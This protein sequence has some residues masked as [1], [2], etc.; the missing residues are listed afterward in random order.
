[1]MQVNT[2][3]NATLALSAAGRVLTTPAQVACC[4]MCR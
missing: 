2:P 1:M 4:I 3:L